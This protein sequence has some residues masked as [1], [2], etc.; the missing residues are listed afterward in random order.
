MLK[1]TD[2]F[3]SGSDQIWNTYV[4]YDPYMFL[5]FA[6]GVKKISYASS[7]GTD[8]VPE[9]YK[10]RIKSALAKY[11][12]ISVRE[13]TAVGVLEYVTN[14]HDIIQVLDPTFLVTPDIWKELAEK[15]VIEFKLPDK[16]ILCYL[17]GKRETYKE[18]LYEIVEKTGITN[19]III[20]SQ[21]N[22]AFTIKN[23]ILYENA[24]PIEFVALINKA[25]LV[26]TD[27]FHATAISINLSKDF[28]EFMRFDDNEE[29][30]Q[31]SRVN[32]LL[33]QYDLTCRKY[34][35]IH[36]ISMIEPVNYDKVQTKLEKDRM[37]SMSYLINSIEN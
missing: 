7:I 17:I 16:Y 3:I 2:V 23:A 13:K 22:E 36:S 10:E 20:K 8:N 33:K 18:Q 27:S 28:I 25:S 34:S 26:C 11:S 5:E 9:Q 4:S 6:K 12:H 31:N 30:S 35:Y 32:D 1:T 15:A 29:A 14:R 24:S 19:I 37:T 21:E